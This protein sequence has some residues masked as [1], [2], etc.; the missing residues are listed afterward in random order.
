MFAIIIAAII[1]VGAFWFGGKYQRGEDPFSF[2]KQIISSSKPQYEFLEARNGVVL[3]QENS[4][5]EQ[6]IHVKLAGQSGWRNISESDSTARNAALSPD[7]EQVAYLSGSSSSEI[8]LKSLITDSQKLVQGQVKSPAIASKELPTT[9]CKW[10]PVRWS[11]DNEHIALFLCESLDREFPSYLVVATIVV[12]KPT[13]TAWPSEKVVQNGMPDA[14]WL[15]YREI[16][17]KTE[18]DSGK[19]KIE[20]VSIP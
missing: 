10:S 1:S 9:I 18:D 15:N 19:E 17:L 5:K 14:I 12:S 4:D 2:F 13:I 16:M 8:V 6:S 20:I 11:P 7:G 3:I